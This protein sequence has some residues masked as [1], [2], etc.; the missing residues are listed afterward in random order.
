MCY[1]RS[2]GCGCAVFFNGRHSFGDRT[3]A[4][5]ISL[6]EVSADHLL[7][8][9]DA[10]MATAKLTGNECPRLDKGGWR[11]ILPILVRTSI[12]RIHFLM[13][14]TTISSRLFFV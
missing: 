14:C 9:A 1:R 5:I 8:D 11:H 10:K 13:R 3:G 7:M 6:P 2:F 12:L 4:H